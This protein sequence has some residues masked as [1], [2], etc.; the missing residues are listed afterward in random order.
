ME[1][2]SFIEWLKSAQQKD[3]AYFDVV[4]ESQEELKILLKDYSNKQ[5]GIALYFFIYKLNFIKNAI[6]DLCETDNLYSANIMYR[7]F[8]EHWLKATYIASRVMIENND[9]VGNDYLMFCNLGEELDYGKSLKKTLDILGLEDD[10]GNVWDNMVEK[11][12]QLETLSVHSVEAKVMQFKYRNIIQ[13]LLKT[14]APGS[15]WIHVI[16]SEYSELS[17][18]VHGGPQANEVVSEEDRHLKYKGMI[19]FVYNMCRF[20]TIYVYGIIAKDNNEKIIH[21]INDLNK[22]EIV[23]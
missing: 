7:V 18:Y 2:D 22:I 3:D 15:D 21:Y 17:S 19:N 13:Y 6:V 10:T 9:D 20:Y 5:S 16:I 11:F 4:K 14:N 1:E 8:L 23:E 12:P